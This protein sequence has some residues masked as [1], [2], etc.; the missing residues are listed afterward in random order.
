MADFSYFIF[1][2]ILICKTGCLTVRVTRWWAGGDNATLPESN[3]SQETACLHL[4]AGTGENA[5]SP[6]RP[7]HYPGIVPRRI[8]GQR[9]AHNIL[10]S[11]RKTCSRK[12][13]FEHKEQDNTEENNPQQQPA[14]HFLLEGQWMWK[15]KLRSRHPAANALD[16]FAVSILL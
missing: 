3:L 12:N 7:V 10:L 2:C 6:S 15:L 16:G 5:Q 14:L 13:G 9:L 8:V 1:E 4:A 11:E